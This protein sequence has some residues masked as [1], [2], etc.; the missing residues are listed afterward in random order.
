M[1]SLESEIQGVLGWYHTRSVRLD[2]NMGESP[3]QIGRKLPCFPCPILSFISAYILV[4]IGDLFIKQLPECIKMPGYQVGGYIRQ[5]M[6]AFVFLG[7]YTLVRVIPIRLLDWYQV[8]EILN[9]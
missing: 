5:N 6:Y 4:F 9:T 8:V 7:P 2:L 3:P 1:S